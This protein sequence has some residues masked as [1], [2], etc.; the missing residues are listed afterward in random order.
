M[1]YYRFY[2]KTQYAGLETDIQN[3]YCNAIIQV[4][5]FNEPL[6]NV[7]KSH[8]KTNC[9]KEFCLS[10]ELGFIVR[11]LEDAKGSNCQA[12][13][14]LRAFGTIPQGMDKR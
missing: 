12:S 7:V 13:N 4:M 1:D 3:S 14:F 5:F 8:I 2:N 6:K 11:M 9:L 10:C